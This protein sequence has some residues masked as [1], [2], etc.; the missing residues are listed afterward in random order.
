MLFNGTTKMF[1]LYFYLELLPRNLTASM[2]DTH[3]DTRIPM[4]ISPLS[5]FLVEI[6]SHT[7]AHFMILK[8]NLLCKVALVAMRNFIF[9]SMKCLTIS[10]TFLYIHLSD[11]RY[12]IT[13]YTLDLDSA[14]LKTFRKALMAIFFFFL[15]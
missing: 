9:G 12:Y 3:R 14:Q 2:L 7:N 6:S 11:S 4:Q 5:V 10:E 1:Q 15:N 13:A 8:T